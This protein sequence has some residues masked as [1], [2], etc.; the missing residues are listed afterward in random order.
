MKSTKLMSSGLSIGMAVAVLAVN[1]CLFKVVKSFTVVFWISFAF[2]MVAFALAIL[3]IKFD[4]GTGERRQIYAMVI[5][6]VITLYLIAQLVVALICTLFL[7]RFILFSFVVQLIILAVFLLLYMGRRRANATVRREREVRGLDLA[8]FKSII[9]SAKEAAAKVDYSAPY[10][11]D[12]QRAVDALSSGQVRSTSEASE[13]EEQIITQ[14]T[15]LS[16]AID[17]KNDKKIISISKEIERL[18]DVRNRIISSSR[19]QL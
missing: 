4:I 3:L 11:K 14:I 12:V 13:V 8:F 17:D 7:S 18:A 15:E 19:A 9:D 16:G 2:S 10:R 5:Y 1:I 6:P